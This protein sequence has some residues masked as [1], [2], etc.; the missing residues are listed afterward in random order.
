MS[1]KSYEY[2]IVY[3]QPEQVIRELNES[4]RNGWELITVFQGQGPVQYYFKRE[5][6]KK[7]QIVRGDKMNKHYVWRELSE[8][9][10]LK[11]PETKINGSFGTTYDTTLEAV[12]DL[13]DCW[14]DHSKDCWRDHS[15]ANYVLVEVYRS[16]GL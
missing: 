1:R 7:E 11:E 2:K 8:D 15:G 10:L 6:A 4:G 16:G 3:I 5:V 13:K 14:R 9:G 12:E